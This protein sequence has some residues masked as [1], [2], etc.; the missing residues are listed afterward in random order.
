MA[1]IWGLLASK[2]VVLYLFGNPYALSLF[3]YGEAQAVVLAYQNFVVFQQHAA[4]H[5]L[6]KTEAKGQLPV[7]LTEMVCGSTK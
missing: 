1:L 2:N 5:F 3:N 6:G 7:T 4:H